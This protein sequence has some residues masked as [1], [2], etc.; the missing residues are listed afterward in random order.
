M[1]NITSNQKNHLV[2]QQCW[3]TDAITFFVILFNPKPLTY[4]IHTLTHPD[5]EA[6]VNAFFVVNWDALS[7]SLSSEQAVVTI[8]NSAMVK[9][10]DLIV[11]GGQKK[12]TWAIY[13][14]S[15]ISMFNIYLAWQNFIGTLSFDADLATHSK[16]I[17]YSKD[18]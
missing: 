15:L 10:L 4:I 1:S 3:S 8:V 14:T 17:H 7:S 2:S 5:T 16:G 18:L 9:K 11:T 6:E 13:V 12:W